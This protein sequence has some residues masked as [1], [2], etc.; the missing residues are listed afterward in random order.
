M[1]GRVAKGAVFGALLAVC[2]GGIYWWSAR[3]DAESGPLTLYGNIDIRQ[4]ALAF[5]GSGRITDLTAEEGD[6]VSADQVIGHLDTTALT[7][8]VKAQAAQVEALHQAFLELEAGARPEEIA[9]ARASVASATAGARLADLRRDRIDRLIATGSGAVSQEDLDRVTAEAEAATAS[10]QQASAALDLIV[11]GAR[12][13]DLAAARARLQSAESQLQLLKFQQSQGELRAPATAVVRSRLKEPGDMVTAQA[14][15][16]ALALTAPKWVRVYV[17]QADL[18]HLREGMPAQ[19][20]SDS[21]PGA[22]VAGHVGYISSVAE[23]TPKVVQTEE[24]RTS[25][26]YEVRVVVDDDADRLRL[27]QPVTVLL[28]AGL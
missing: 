19:V 24:L 28:E 14:P 12:Q 9:Q 8:Q 5:D 13:E 17:R 2:A 1:P 10:L 16:Y 11:A 3:Q 23:F 27:G 25:L 18:G 21:F 7:L 15:V 20:L 22:P 4:V 6:T 26:V